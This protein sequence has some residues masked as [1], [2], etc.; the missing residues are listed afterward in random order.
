MGTR[1]TFRVGRTEVLVIQGMMTDK[2]QLGNRRNVRHLG[3]DG[4]N[5]AG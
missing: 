2:T 4:Q 5:T 3:D 1:V